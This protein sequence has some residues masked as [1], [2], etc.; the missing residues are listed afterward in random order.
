M[1]ILPGSLDY[2][3]HNGI[4]PCIPYEAYETAPASLMKSS[5]NNLQISES[6]NTYSNHLNNYN[7]YD[8]VVMNNQGL[9]YTNDYQ[10]NIQSNEVNNGSLN[11]DFKTSPDVF[12]L[13]NTQGFKNDANSLLTSQQNFREEITKD[14]SSGGSKLKTSPILCGFISAATIL[15]TVW[16]ILRG[17]KK[18]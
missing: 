6:E 18:P 10:N 2:L 5:R 11:Y 8:H 9:N 12:V 15:G 4:L 1:A 7:S 13:S 14:V 16:L 3:Y 17:K